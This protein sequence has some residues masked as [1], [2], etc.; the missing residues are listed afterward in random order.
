MKNLSEQLR[1]L[2]LGILLGGMA[3]APVLAASKAVTLTLQDYPPFMGQNLPHKGLMSRVVVA[4]FA[5]AGIAVT[6]VPTPNNRAIEA[7]RRGLYDGS[8]GWA[9]SPEREKDLHYT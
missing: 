2:A 8:F 3:C 6:L 5:R 7:P 1:R 9:R 4:A